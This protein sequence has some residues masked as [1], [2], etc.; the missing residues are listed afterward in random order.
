VPE[1]TFPSG[2]FT[3]RRDSG[4]GTVATD[5]SDQAFLEQ[6]ADGTYDYKDASN[7]ITEAPMSCAMR[8]AVMEEFI[9]TKDPVVIK[10]FSKTP[11]FH[12]I[13]QRLTDP[14]K[15]VACYLVSKKD[16]KAK[17]GTVMFK[18]FSSIS[19]WFIVAV[20]DDLVDR[21]NTLHTV[22]KNPE[23]NG[24]FSVDWEVGKNAKGK[25][26]IVLTGA[27]TNA[28][29]PVDSNTNLKAPVRPYTDLILGIYHKTLYD[30]FSLMAQKLAKN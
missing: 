6:Q 9:G 21:V 10:E 27:D 1:V 24:L 20:S 15:T 16:V 17:D 30:G 12:E 22:F 13:Y 19:P 8:D 29:W 23:Q 4:D 7:V 11:V 26:A 3:W 14:S 28:N 5:Y 2:K 18:G 25:D